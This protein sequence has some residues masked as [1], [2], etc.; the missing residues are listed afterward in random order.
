MGFLSTLTGPRAPAGWHRGGGFLFGAGPQT[1][2]GAYLLAQTPYSQLGEAAEAQS[3]QNP[4]MRTLLIAGLVF[5]AGATL[6]QV[7][8]DADL[9]PTGVRAVLDDINSIW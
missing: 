1:C 8:P 7:I 5:L 2:G 6:L 3:W 9:I 4:D